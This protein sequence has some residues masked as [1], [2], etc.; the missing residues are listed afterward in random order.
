MNLPTLMEYMKMNMNLLF[1]DGL[2]YKI[3]I[4]PLLAS[5][6]KKALKM[7]NGGGRV[8]DIA[9]GTGSLVFRLSENASRVTGIDLSEPMILGARRTKERKLIQNVDFFVK[10]VTKLCEYSDNEFDYATISMVVHQFPEQIAKDVLKEV[11][12]I[13]KEVIIID[14]MFPILSSFQRLLVYFIERLAGGEHYQN[15]LHYMQ[16]SGIDHYL[17]QLQINKIEQ[18][19]NSR[20]ALT[21]LR[22]R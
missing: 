16:N 12:R 8:I 14:Y 18:P 3:F 9:C 7:I 5:S 1:L 11:F 10:D 17:N 19:A 4:D 6:H 15:F 20:G 22:C 21:V 13:A 2:T